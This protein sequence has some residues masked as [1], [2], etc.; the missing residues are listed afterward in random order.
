MSVLIK[1]KMLQGDKQQR[2]NIDRV[3]LP[4]LSPLANI[5]GERLPAEDRQQLKHHVTYSAIYQ[6][7]DRLLPNSLED[8]ERKIQYLCER[9]Q[10]RAINR[11]SK[12]FVMLLII[13]H[14]C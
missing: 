1:G 3:C 11:Q 9:A 13:F 7:I 6:L 12:L 4:I 10:S 14:M 2:M 5:I 8:N